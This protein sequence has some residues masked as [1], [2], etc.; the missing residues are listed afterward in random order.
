LC[1]PASDQNLPFL[2][3]H[4]AVLN[5]AIWVRVARVHGWAQA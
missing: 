1:N 3:E 5:W 2:N 4:L